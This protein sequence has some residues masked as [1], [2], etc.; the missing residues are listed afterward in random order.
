[1]EIVRELCCFNVYIYVFSFHSFYAAT[2]AVFVWL[3]LL[4][5]FTLVAVNI[6]IMF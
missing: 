5:C 4:M 6:I 1:M 2:Y 3:M